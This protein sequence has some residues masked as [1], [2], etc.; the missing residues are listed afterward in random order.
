M[1]PPS[2]DIGP[3]LCLVV[4]RQAA[5]HS[6]LQ[7]V[8]EAVSGGVDWLQIRAREL[9][10][11]AL[12]DFARDLAGRAREA[13][14]AGGRPL[15]VIVNRR[16]DISLAL[17]QAGAHLG[18]DAVDPVDA[19][20]LLGPALPIGVSA[21]GASE[22]E[23]AAR[24]GADYAHLAPIFDPLSKARERPALG[25]RALGEAARQGIPVLAQ[26]GIDAERCRNVI[27]AGA[28]GVAVTGAISHAERPGEA[29]RSLRR[30]LDAAWGQRAR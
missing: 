4:D 2:S 13:A 16:L 5:R 9:D 14:V 3:I 22:V 21:H 23:S 19:R 8:G 24:A 1:A 15:T 20:E 29:A 10:G 25:P 28:S 12:L 18:F 27:E 6:P 7:V 11:V 26:G 30:A 17:G